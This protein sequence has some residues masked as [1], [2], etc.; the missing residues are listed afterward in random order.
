MLVILINAKGDL[1][2][3]TAYSTEKFNWTLAYVEISPVASEMYVVD[4]QC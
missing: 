3:K 1:D 4:Q 2:H